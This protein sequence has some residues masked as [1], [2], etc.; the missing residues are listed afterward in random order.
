MTHRTE[1]DAIVIGAGLAGLSCAAHLAK[2][3]KQ[4][5]VV[6]QHSRP[7]GLWTSFSRRGLIFDC[8]TH[9]VTEPQTLNRMLDE[10]GCQPVEFEQLDS[11]GRY[12]GP[13]LSTGPT[14]PP[15]SRPP[16]PGTSSWDPTRRPSNRVFAPPSPP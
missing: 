8:S 3:G 2:A 12:V 16:P 7:G 10:L 4:V 1:W 9:W 15:A 11:L 13:P 5:V 14:G 6:E